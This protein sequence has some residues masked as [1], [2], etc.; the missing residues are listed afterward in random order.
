MEEKKF[1]ITKETQDQMTAKEMEGFSNGMRVFSKYLELP[2]KTVADAKETLW[3]EDPSGKLECY[4]VGFLWA[5]GFDET[6]QRAKAV[7]ATKAVEEKKP[8]KKA[9]K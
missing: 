4:M 1:G 7:E 9:K 2:F 8:V 6:G 5:L 3:F